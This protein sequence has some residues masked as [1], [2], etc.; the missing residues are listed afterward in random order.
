MG[1]FY[2]ISRSI[3]FIDDVVRQPDWPNG[4]PDDIF[5]IADSYGPDITITAASG[6]YTMA[7][8]ESLPFTFASVHGTSRSDIVNNAKLTQI[9]FNADYKAAK[10][11]PLQRWE[12]ALRPSGRV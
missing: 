3:V 6:P 1:R 2:W 4:A 7:P 12:P 8:G 9:L 10:S 5:Q 11:V